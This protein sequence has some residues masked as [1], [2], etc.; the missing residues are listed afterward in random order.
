[1]TWEVRLPDG[2]EAMYAMF[3]ALYRDRK[4]KRRVVLR[5]ESAYIL[6]HG[7]NKRQRDAKKVNWQTLVYKAYK[8]E[9]IRP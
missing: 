3:F 4:R 7:L 9:E 6:E 1:M 5:V 8:G 2:I